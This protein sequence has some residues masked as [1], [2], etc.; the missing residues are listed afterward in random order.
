MPNLDDL[1]QQYEAQKASSGFNSATAKGTSPEA[2][3]NYVNAGRAYA[4]ELTNQGMSD[5]ADPV[6]ADYLQKQNALLSILSRQEPQ[7]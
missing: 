3:Q 2:L 5:Q 4:N 7:S 6:R 1:K